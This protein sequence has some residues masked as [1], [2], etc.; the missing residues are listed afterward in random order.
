MKTISVIIGEKRQD[1]AGDRR[2]RPRALARETEDRLLD[3][4]NLIIGAGLFV[5][6]WVLG[7]GA[8]PPNVPTQSAVVVGTA[9]AIASVATLIAFEAWEVWLILLAAACA[10]LSPWI[11]GFAGT[12]A[13]VVHLVAGA[14]SAG[15]AVARIA[16]LRRASA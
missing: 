2:S 8:E 1:L 11:F 3:A 13:M 15:L 10:V 4:S 14:I 5:S 16:R 12:D 6:P 7:F 9:I